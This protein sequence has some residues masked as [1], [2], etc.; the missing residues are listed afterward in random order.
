MSDAPI[1]IQSDL[2]TAEATKELTKD[3][4]SCPLYIWEG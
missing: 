1:S 2:G 3:V 4:P